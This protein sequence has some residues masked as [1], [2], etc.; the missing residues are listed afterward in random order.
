MLTVRVLVRQV[1]EAPGVSV[2]IL[3]HRVQK[4]GQGLVKRGFGTGEGTKSNRLSQNEL[5]VNAMCFQTLSMC[6]VR[7]FWLS[8]LPDWC[9]A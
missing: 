4:V 9:N 6:L 7:C 2:P 8:L 3:G 5:R 1:G